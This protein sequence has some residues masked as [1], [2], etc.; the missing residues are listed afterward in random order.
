MNA[1]KT[2]GVLIIGSAITLALAF[3]PLLISGDNPLTGAQNASAY[4]NH[5]SG[6]ELFKYILFCR[7]INSCNNCTKRQ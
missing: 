6:D 4:N 5:L 3:L 1:K 7:P 2:I